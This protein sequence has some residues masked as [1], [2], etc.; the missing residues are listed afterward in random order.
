M[1][2]KVGDRVRF[3]EGA[4][5][6]GG[7]ATV[8]HIEPYLVVQAD[9]ASTWGGSDGLVT[10]SESCLDLVLVVADSTFA[11][12]SHSRIA[13]KTDTVIC[14]RCGCNEAIV[15]TGTSKKTGKS[16]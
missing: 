2:L 15:A 14:P 4:A 1:K 11:T 16:G 6:P 10:I 12:R 9:D 3:N 8:L 5:V 13:A 7:L